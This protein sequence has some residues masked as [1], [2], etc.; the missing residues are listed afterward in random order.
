ML[1]TVPTLDTTVTPHRWTATV[2]R[3]SGPAVVVSGATYDEALAAARAA[4]AVEQA[5]PAPRQAFGATHL[6]R[7]NQATGA[8]SFRRRR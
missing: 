5:R 6:G 7:D 3:D 2:H 4:G 8:N 1:V